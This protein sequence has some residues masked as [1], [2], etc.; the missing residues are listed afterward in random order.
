METW[1]IVAFALGAVLLVVMIL[2]CSNY[3]SE[4]PEDVQFK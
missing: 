3:E 2:R 1:K 4:K